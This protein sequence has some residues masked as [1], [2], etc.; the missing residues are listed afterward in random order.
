MGAI[1]KMIILELLGKI[2]SFANSFKPSANGC[3]KPKNPITFGPFLLCIIPII[4]LSAMVKY[5][6]EISKGTTIA[7][8]FSKVQIININIFNLNSDKDKVGFEP[9][10]LPSTTVFK[11]DA[12]NHSATYPII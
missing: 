9:T 4:F 7:R 10:V 8:I 11:T 6:T 1:T 5:A 2:V 3:N 12:L